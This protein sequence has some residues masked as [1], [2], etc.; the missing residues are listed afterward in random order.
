MKKTL[1]FFICIIM[2]LS[3]APTAFASQS[4]EKIYLAFGDSIAAGFGIE[5]ESETYPAI[6]A[7]KYGLSLQNLAA[8]G[9][10]SDDMLTVIANTPAIKE[11]SLITVSIGGNDLI[12]NNNVFLAYAVREKLCS[13]GLSEENAEKLIKELKISGVFDGSAINFETIEADMESVFSALHANLRA[14]II[15][16]RAANP[17][18]VVIIQ[19]LY[20]PYLGNP[21]YN[22]FGFDVGVLIDEYIQKINAVYYAV[23]SE[24][25]GNIL[26]AD[27]ADGMNGNSEYFYTSWDFHPTS[28]GHSHMAKVI[29]EVYS[30]AAQTSAIPETEGTTAS[31][32]APAETSDATTASPQTQSEQT[33][34]QTVAQSPAAEP[35]ADG[36]DHTTLPVIISVAA[37]A[38]ICICAGVMIKKTK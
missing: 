5:N 17:D 35:T 29:G 38:A 9:A 23:Q 16:I 24:T 13:L 33:E 31:T 7:Q 21:E 11:A 3:L 34:A 10:R 19:T 26:I 12:D 32:A 20:N 18:A 2:I 30:K 37:V 6:I 8:N 27:V 22:I 28:A 15:L 25:D 4:E 14:A 36:K 1:V